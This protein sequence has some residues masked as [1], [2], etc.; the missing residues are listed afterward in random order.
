[1]RVL[2]KLRLLCDDAQNLLAS[3]IHQHD[4]ALD[5]A[6][7][8]PLCLRH[9]LRDGVRSGRAVFVGWLLAGNRPSHDV[10]SD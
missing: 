1:M 6:D 5:P 9:Q 2:R 7:F 4:L 10:G 8:E 3:R